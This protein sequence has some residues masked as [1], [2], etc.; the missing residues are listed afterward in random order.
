MTSIVGILASLCTGPL[1]EWAGP[2]RVIT[3]AEV[4]SAALW[5]VLAFLPNKA[6]FF[7]ARAGL[8]AAVYIIS[9]ASVPLL[10]ELSPNNIRGTMTALTEVSMGLGVLVGYLLA[11]LFDWQVATA[12]ST[13]TAGLLVPALLLVPE[14]SECTYGV[15]N[16]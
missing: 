6:V 12:L 4:L 14:V 16:T 3:A 9:T 7:I 11:Y 2:R 15:H 5:L 1:V 13:L 8:A 10:A